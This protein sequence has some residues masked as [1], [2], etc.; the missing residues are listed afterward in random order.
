MGMLA[1]RLTGNGK[2]STRNYFFS[3]ELKDV[4]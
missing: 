1:L 3:I 2:T 4:F